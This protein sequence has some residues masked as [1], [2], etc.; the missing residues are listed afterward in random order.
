[1]TEHFSTEQLAD[2][3]AGLL[4][5]A[6]EREV[7]RHLADCPDCTARLESVR[8]VSQVLAAQS[9]PR[10]PAAVFARL[11]QSIGALASS[12]PPNA[13][14]TVG[15]RRAAE[16][17]RRPAHEL[18]LGDTELSSGRKRICQARIRHHGR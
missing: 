10:M 18:P 3:A 6:R 11:H 12:G 8:H 16:G 1:M 4:E 17:E 9:A 14:F 13:E 5:P 15:S 2:H 7:A